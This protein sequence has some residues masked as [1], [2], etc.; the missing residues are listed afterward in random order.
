[1]FESIT[2]Y[3]K[4]DGSNFVM[5]MD[6][7]VTRTNSFGKQMNQIGNM[8]RGSFAVYTVSRFVSAIGSAADR[9]DELQKKTGKKIVSDDDLA[10]AKAINRELDQLK[11]NI[12]IEIVKGVSVLSKGFQVLYATAERLVGLTSKDIYKQNLQTILYGK[13]PVKAADD[14]KK[15]KEYESKV[16]E[17]REKLNPTSPEEKRRQS[18]Q[19]IA[20]LEKQ[21]ADRRVA[22]NEFAFRERQVQLLEE[23]IRLKSIEEEISKQAVKDEEEYEKAV[24]ESKRMIEGIRAEEKARYE[25]QAAGAAE[26]KAQAKREVEE[27]EGALAMERA[28]GGARQGRITLSMSPSLDRHFGKLNQTALRQEITMKR[29]LQRL[30]RGR[31]QAARF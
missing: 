23:Q 17:L 11:T 21:M 3:L 16:T 5:G 15:R 25:A 24:A 30:E 2:A 12:S 6:G 19:K 29:M 20:D 22:K 31:Q 28:T 27:R 10:N 1:M 14:L 7:A 4:L 9:V 18:L 13:D 8:I 26:A